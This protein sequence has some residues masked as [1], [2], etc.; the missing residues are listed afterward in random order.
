MIEVIDAEAARRALHH[1]AL[2]CP[3]CRTGRLR[4]W[5]RA[6]HRAITGAHGV[7]RQLRP[8]RGRCSDCRATHVLLPADI[9]VGRAYAVDVIG[10]A[11]AAFARGTGRRTI[12]AELGVPASTVADWTRRLTANA[13]AITL[14]AVRRVV[15]LDQDL[16]ST[17]VHARPAAAALDA[18]GRLATAITARWPAAGRDPWRLLALA[19]GGRLLR[20]SYPG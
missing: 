3:S 16:L 7:R 1:G 19:T 2:T 13:D 17:T 9:L 11:L 15:A 12:A 20:P 10:P 14:D 18:L 5:G 8:D 4:P 6:R